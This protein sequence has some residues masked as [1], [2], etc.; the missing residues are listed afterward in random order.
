MS[1]GSRRHFTPQQKAEIV[2]RHLVGKEPISDLAGE[3]QVQR[4]EKPP[5]GNDPRGFSL[6]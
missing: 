2:R 6:D 3:F 4:S 1:N 5:R